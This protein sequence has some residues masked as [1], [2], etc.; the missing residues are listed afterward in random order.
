MQDF[1]QIGKADRVMCVTLDGEPHATDE[2]ELGKPECFCPALRHA[3]DTEGRLTEK[4]EEPL[5]A[6]IRREADGWKRAKLKLIA[7]MRGIPF[8]ELNQRELERTR[9]R[10][11]W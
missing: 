5:A 10:R 3:V 1:K 11:M 4:R 6:D 8:D 2:P 7:G 9:V